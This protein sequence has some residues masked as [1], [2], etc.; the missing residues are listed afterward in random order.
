MTMFFKNTACTAEVTS[1]YNITLEKHVQNFE[2]ASCTI[3][4][5]WVFP[6][7]ANYRLYIV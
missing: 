7:V 2:H 4:A 3:H 5:D 6:T 1:E